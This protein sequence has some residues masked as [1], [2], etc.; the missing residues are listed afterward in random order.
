M[1][2]EGMA[3]HGAPLYRISAGW[4]PLGQSMIAPWYFDFLRD[5]AHLPWPRIPQTATHAMVKMAAE[6]MAQR[7]S[8]APRPAPVVVVG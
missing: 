2:L 8:G 6:R 5:L 3:T 4:Y 7:R 1:G